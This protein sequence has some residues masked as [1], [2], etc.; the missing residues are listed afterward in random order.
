[1]LQSGNR[2]FAVPLQYTVVEPR[3]SAIKE[4]NIEPCV[5]M[6]LGTK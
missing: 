6:G 2:H 1:M 3:V 4:K 5:K